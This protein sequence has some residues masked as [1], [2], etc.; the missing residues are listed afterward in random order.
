MNFDDLSSLVY[1][2]SLLYGDDESQVVS[3]DDQDRVAVHACEPDLGEV[4]ISFG[5]DACEEIVTDESE[6]PERA[7]Q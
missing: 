7:D 3:P 4:A 2:P 1:L 5:L 6:P